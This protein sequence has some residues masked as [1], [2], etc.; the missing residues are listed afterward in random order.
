MSP[1]SCYKNRL[2]CLWLL[3]EYSCS[4]YP[5]CCKRSWNFFFGGGLSDLLCNKLAQNVMLNMVRKG[6]VSPLTCLSFKKSWSTSILKFQGRF[7]EPVCNSRV[8]PEVFTLPVSK[9]TEFVLTTWCVVWTCSECHVN[10]HKRCKDSISNLCGVNQKILNELLEIVRSSTP[11]KP[12]TAALPPSSVCC[13]IN[14]ILVS[15]AKGIQAVKLCTNRI[16]QFLTRG[17]G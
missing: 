14:V 2:A 13:F 6:L 3:D 16:L 8:C 15:Y 17:A 9:K 12:I 11:A 4:W 1:W 7:S 10:C 5:E